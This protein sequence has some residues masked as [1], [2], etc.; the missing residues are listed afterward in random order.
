MQT[1]KFKMITPLNINFD[2]LSSEED[3]RTK[4]I[5]SW[6]KA[7]GFQED[8]ILIERGFKIKIGKQEKTTPRSDILVKSNITGRNLIVIEVK[9]K[10]HKLTNADRTQATSYASLL[11]Q[12]APLTILTNGS[13]TEVYDTISRKRIDTEDTHDV[14]FSDIELRPSADMLCAKSEAIERLISLSSDNF[15]DFCKGQVTYRI[16]P[17]KG[18]EIDSD[19]KYIPAL[20]VNRN[21]LDKKLHQKLQ[22]KKCNLV[23][24]TGR[25]QHGKTCFMCNAVEKYNSVGK[26]CFF[27]PAIGLK[28]GLINSIREDF[29]WHTRYAM[30]ETEVIYRINS[31]LQ[32]INES[33]Y[34]FIDGWNEL[35]TKSA[36]L[37]DQACKRLD[38]NA[39][40]IKI[41]LSTTSPSLSRLQSDESGN[42]TFVADKLCINEDLAKRL[43]TVDRDKTEKSVF[44]GD[45]SYQETEEAIEK[46]CEVFNISDESAYHNRKILSNPFYLRLA[47]KIYQSSTFPNELTRT[48]LLSKS[49]IKKGE[50][51]GFPATK[52]IQLLNELGHWF[53][54]NHRISS[55]DLSSVPNTNQNLVKLQEA[56]ILALFFNQDIPEFYFYF[57]HDRNYAIAIIARKW[58][59]IF[60]LDSQ[61]EVVINELKQIK[62]SQIRVEAANWFFRL[63]ESKNCLKRAITSITNSNEDLIYYHFLYENISTH[64]FD[65]GFMEYIY[66]ERIIDLVYEYIKVNANTLSQYEFNKKLKILMSL[67]ELT[68][69]F[70]YD[71]YSLSILNYVNKHSHHLS[72]N[73]AIENI[74]LDDSSILLSTKAIILHSDNFELDPK[75]LLNLIRKYPS[76]KSHLILSFREGFSWLVDQ[77]HSSY[78]PTMCPSILSEKFNEYPIEKDEL[79]YR[80]YL[81]LNEAFRLISRLYG[82][83]DFVQTLHGLVSDLRHCCGFYDDYEEDVYY[84]NPNQLEIPFPKIQNIEAS[85]A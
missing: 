72:S 65:D 68:Q 81:T 80:E 30:S 51:V 49:L 55:T 13:D 45:F 26:P 44:V 19:K 58:D 79:L 31:I 60:T 22:D 12:I 32:K 39:T 74:I 33:L 63:P 25:P 62:L 10:N 36:L 85:K 11:N 14:L 66:D 38:A 50:R 56:A 46:Y 75:Y 21:E 82:N 42:P 73:D 5:F 52:T 70:A 29:E 20:Y 43:A 17:L 4:V 15:L 23:L 35:D 28:G 3:V 54:E 34:I 6:L 78:Y 67:N 7:H 71:S 24:V 53:Y 64:E 61:E 48:E 40:N 37:L 84:Y 47:A 8:E 57:T 83:I 9:K 2:N 69:E 16:R 59:K 41:I 18:E 1:N 76:K 77:I 27:Y